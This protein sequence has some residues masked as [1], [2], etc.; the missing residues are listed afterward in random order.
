M[1]KHY[2]E[3]DIDTEDKYGTKW[4]VGA[5]IEVTK[6]MYGTGDSPTGYEATITRVHNGSF[7]EDLDTLSSR[8]L[9]YLMEE[10]IDVYVNL[11]DGY[12]G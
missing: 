8:T 6:D 10:A 12:H 5:K 11:G 2:V 1:S 4:T 7:D 3:F 9:D